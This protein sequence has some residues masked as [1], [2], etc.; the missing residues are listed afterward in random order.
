MS[1]VNELSR[2]KLYLRAANVGVFSSLADIIAMY[3]LA[4][5]SNIDIR[6]QLYISSGISLFIGFIGQKLWT[7][8]NK[9][10]GKALA[11]QIMAFLVWEILFIMVI[12]EAVIYITEPMNEKLRTMS[13]Q[14]MKDSWILSKLF[15]LEKDDSGKER[16]ELNTLTNI[17]IKH[18]CIFLIFTFVSL[19]IYKVIFKY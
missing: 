4:T 17:G 8:R 18:I 5:Y 9:L 3:L 14:T 1:D 13:P 10:R 7:F 12:A 2:F 11:K 19:P 15:H 16:V 6:Y